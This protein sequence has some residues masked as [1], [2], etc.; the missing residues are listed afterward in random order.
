MW[1]AAKIPCNWN[2][3]FWYTKYFVSALVPN[4]GPNSVR[5][6]K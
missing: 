6:V 4:V 1:V 5:L 2:K 3:L